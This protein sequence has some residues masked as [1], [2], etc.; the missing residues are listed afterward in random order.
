MPM[1]TL[2][3]PSFLASLAEDGA[4]RPAAFGRAPGARPSPAIAMRRSQP[5][6]S[7]LD[8]QALASIRAEAMD[9]V[10]HAVEVL[11][12]TA[13]R[14]A[15]QARSDALE[16]GFQ[17]ARRIIEAE[18][19][20]SPETLFGLVRSALRRAGDS[21]KIVIRLHPEDARVIA[22]TV[23]SGDLAVSAA[24]VEVQPD[25]TL[26][27]GDCLVDTDFGQ[28]DG[29]LQ[30]RLEELHRAAVAAVEEGAA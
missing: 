13:E 29:R 8:V 25:A 2:R 30:T 21:R 1:G 9:K 22:A 26:E 24:G 6:P 28:V 3:R 10:A 14:L 18:L 19:Q 16:I 4:A 17:V 7:P 5:E 15:E 23:A 27:P 11:R 12:L 20:R